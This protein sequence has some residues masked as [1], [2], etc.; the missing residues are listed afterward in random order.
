MSR[1]SNSNAEEDAGGGEFQP[2]IMH[3]ESQQPMGGPMLSAPAT[4]QPH[5]NSGLD[6]SL[7]PI[8]GAAGDIINIGG[9]G[10]RNGGGGRKRRGPR[11]EFGLGG[12]SSIVGREEDR[13]VPPP[14][15]PNPWFMSGPDRSGRNGG[16][17]GGGGGTGA[18]AASGLGPASGLVVD[19]GAGG[20][21]GFGGPTPRHSNHR[22]LPSAPIPPAEMNELIEKWKNAGVSSLDIGDSIRTVADSVSPNE[23]RSVLASVVM[24]AARRGILD[25]TPYITSLAD[26]LR[27]EDG[28]GQ[29]QRTRTEPAGTM[30]I[31]RLTA[32]DEMAAEM[33]ADLLRNGGEHRDLPEWVRDHTLPALPNLTKLLRDLE[34]VVAAGGND[35]VSTITGAFRRVEVDEV[36]SEVGE[37]FVLEFQ[38]MEKLTREKKVAISRHLLGLGS[39]DEC[40]NRFRSVKNTD[41]KNALSALSKAGYQNTADYAMLLWFNGFGAKDPDFAQTYKFPMRHISFGQNN[42]PAYYANREAFWTLLFFEEMPAALPQHLCESFEEMKREKERIEE[43]EKRS[44]ESK[45]KNKKKSSK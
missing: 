34:D 13:I 33:Y 28:V 14:G 8:L 36:R 7:G 19:V 22:A 38:P 23:K 3:M 12:G 43:K 26:L 25:G 21:D 44:K 37:N 16:G 35:E 29:Q 40:Q 11:P 24:E 32:L 42:T 4:Q 1:R 6:P 9:G 30:P 45:N 27:R 15:N 31:T 41:F 18:G 17:G 2:R 5:P 39:K 20:F 10:G